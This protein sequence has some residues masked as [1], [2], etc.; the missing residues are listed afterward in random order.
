M[1]KTLLLFSVLSISLAQAQSITVDDTLSTGDVMYYYAADTGATNYDNITGSGA[2]WD[3]SNLAYYDVAGATIA[4]DTVIDIATSSYAT[5][6]PNADYHDKFTGGVQTFFSNTPD[7]VVTHGFVFST[8]TNEYVIRYNIDP[9]KSAH[10][11]MV[12]GSS[13]TDAIDG[14]AVLPTV[15]TTA[16]SGSATITVDG[17]GTMIIGGNTY[18]DVVRV[19][20]VENL[21][22]TII[23]VG[24]VSVTRTSY[25]YYSPSTSD[26]PIFIHGQV[27]ADLGATGTIDLKTVWSKDMLSGYAGVDE[28]TSVKPELAVYPN[29]ATTN[30]TIT[31]NNATQLVI[32]NTVGKEIISI[33]N[34]SNTEV[35]DLT[36]LPKG[37]YFVQVKNAQQLITKKLVIK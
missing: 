34:P 37:I 1:K 21:T 4:Q 18:S 35:I 16:L 19:K 12:L 9:L 24:P 5:D 22:G 6:Y 7:S 25:I 26:M 36:N 17:T 31:S 20:T 14:D 32:Y 30:V 8:G 23:V 28:L 15:G 2:T 10:F 33:N 11:D 29:P 27:F 3:Y 13:Y